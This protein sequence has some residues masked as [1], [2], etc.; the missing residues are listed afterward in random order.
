MRIKRFEAKD[1]QSALA[2]VKQEMGDDAII[3]G[4]KS[5]GGKGMRRGVEVVA[6]M[7][8]DLDNLLE[9]AEEKYASR[10]NPPSYGYHTV[11]RQ[12]NSQTASQPIKP[13][14]E[15]IHSEAHDLRLRFANLLK[16]P[17]STKSGNEPASTP[18]GGRS[19]APPQAKRPV[20][21][22]EVKKWRDQLIDKIQLSSGPRDSHQAQ[23]IIALVGA[24]GVGKTTTAAKLAAWHSLRQGRSVALISMDCYRIGA[25]DQ[26][27]TYAN[28]MRLPCEIV[29]RKKDMSR[30]ISR[31][32]DKDVII[33]D[34]AGKSPYDE[35]HIAELNDWFSIDQTHVSP[36]L[37]LSATTKKEDLNA[38][39][40]SYANLPLA[41]LILTK[42]DETR[43]YAA[44]CQQV[45]AA[46]LPVSYLGTGQRVPEDFLAASKDFLDLLFK[47]GWQAAAPQAA[48]G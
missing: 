16:R 13:P 3:L 19:L 25:T 23:E 28:I 30:A 36:H 12:T 10:S 38:I 24:T 18:P 45:V 47:Q 26:L 40:K 31:H 1:T 44:L 9:T 8:Y 32:Q 21:P 48:S 39:L 29:L 4:T 11:R 5:I 34:T 35:R 20:N 42:L 22:I 2:L 41:G 37:V 43:A 6:A 14:A 46:A 15:K 33:I 7:D 27:R 17:T